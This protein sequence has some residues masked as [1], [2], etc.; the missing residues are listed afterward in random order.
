MATIWKILTWILKALPSPR[1]SD[2]TFY[3]LHSGFAGYGLNDPET[4]KK[5]KKEKKVKMR[6]IA[7]KIFPYVQQVGWK[8]ESA[9]RV[10]LPRQ[11]NISEVKLLERP[12]W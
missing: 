7:L 8:R 4:K 3:D 2:P 9:L 6:S 5:K 12:S 10:L 11:G 1:F